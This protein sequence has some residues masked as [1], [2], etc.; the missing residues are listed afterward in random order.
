MQ[1]GKKWLAVLTVVLGFSIAVQSPVYGGKKVNTKISAA[2]KVDKAALEA[3]V[4]H[5][6]VW[7]PQITVTVADPV[8]SELS[9]FQKLTVIGSA[10]TVKSLQVFHVSADGRKIVQ[11][12]IY[13][14]KEN[15][16]REELSKLKTGNGPALGTPGAPVVLVLYTDFECPFC[17]EEAKM[18]RQNL[19]S[20]YPKE[21]RL[22][23]KDFPLTPIHPWAKPAAIAGRCIYKQ[24]EAMFWQYHDWIFS[25]Q[26][27]I[28]PENLKQ[29]IMDW[30]QNKEIDTLQLGQCIDGKA[31]AAEVDATIAEGS[32]LQLN[33]TPTLYI[34]GR[35]AKPGLNWTQLKAIIDFELNYQKTAHNAGD[36]SCCEVTL[37]SPV[38]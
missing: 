19:V 32:A 7:G 28:K 30:A 23:F 36:N 10:G 31:A 21:V 5:L 15:P 2:A 3:Y 13:D 25:Q 11:G 38:Q 22:Y 29:K 24:N 14:I 35:K 9:G 18:L 27:A 12:Q 8:P 17:R 26:D 1:A 6:F 34:N 33:A 16:F 37:P 20:T 4:R